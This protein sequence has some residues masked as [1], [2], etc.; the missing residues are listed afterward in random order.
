LDQFNQIDT[1]S[2]IEE[3][4]VSGNKEAYRLLEKTVCCRIGMGARADVPAP[5]SLF[6][7]VI[8]ALSTGN[9]EVHLPDLEKTLSLLKALQKEGYSLSFQDD[10]S[11]SCEKT[12]S[13]LK[14]SQEYARAKSITG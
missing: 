1:R 10:N 9:G 2:L 5:P 4:R 8:V 12:I 6:I 3:A 13:P 14:I 11:I 7:E